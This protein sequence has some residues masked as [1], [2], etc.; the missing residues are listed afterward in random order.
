MIQSILLTIGLFVF[1]K[2]IALPYL[3][4]LFYVKQGILIGFFAPIVG[5]II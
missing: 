3:K 5:G 4:L 1:L 2:K